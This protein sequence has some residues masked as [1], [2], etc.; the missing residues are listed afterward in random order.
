MKRCPQCNSVYADDLSFCLTDG[1]VLESSGSQETIFLPK[2]PEFVSSQQTVKQGVNPIFAYLSVFLLALI[3]GG[4][5]I[6]AIWYFYGGN[7][8]TNNS[9]SPNIEPKTNSTQNSA[10]KIEKSPIVKV[11][12]PIT[13]EAARNLISDWTIAQNSK[14]FAKYKIFYDTSF[15]GIKRT[16]KGSVSSYNYSQWIADRQAMMKK[17]D[18]MRVRVEDLSITVQNNEAVVE[19]KQYF[20][21][22]SYADFGPKVIKIKMTE[23]GAKIFYEELKSATLITD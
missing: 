18:V 20:Y 9:F 6:S 5:I 23:N 22:K 2:N 7:S 16:V 21:V 19:F 10:T 8:I 4:G 1:A 14:D 13:E 3:L 15:R 12:P 11:L 17:T